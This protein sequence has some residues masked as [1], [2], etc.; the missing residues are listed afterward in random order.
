MT[1]APELPAPADSPLRQF[2]PFWKLVATAVMVALVLIL[3][4]LAPLVAVFLV[5]LMLCQLAR[6]PWRWI[7]QRVSVLLPLVL[8]LVILLPLVL[9]DDGPAWLLFGG[10]RVSL[11]GIATAFRISLKA[12]SV[13]LFMLVL[14]GTTPMAALLRAAQ[15]LFVPG[16]LLQLVALTYRY[17]MLLVEEF[18]RLRTALRVRGFRGRASL[19]SYRVIGNVTGTLLVRSLE[20]AER[21]GQAMRCRGFDGRFRCLASSRTRPADVA[22]FLA[23]LSG[24]AAAVLADCLLR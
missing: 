24:A 15:L 22:M 12:V 17:L 3:D 9:H 11:Y 14:L 10:L 2:G 6:L 7:G 21:V 1:L 16:F 18:G 8:G 4:H 5:S 20:R 13:L 19:H 23:V